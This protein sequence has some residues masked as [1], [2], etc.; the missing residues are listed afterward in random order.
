MAMLRQAT[1]KEGIVFQ[2]GKS[3][4][5]DNKLAAGIKHSAL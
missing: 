2:T 3:F 1:P 5:I 4:P